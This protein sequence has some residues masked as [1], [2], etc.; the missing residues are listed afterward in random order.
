[1]RPSPFDQPSKKSGLYEAPLYGRPG[2]RDPRDSYTFEVFPARPDEDVSDWSRIPRDNDDYDPDAIGFDISAANEGTDYVLTISTS[3]RPR[4]QWYSRNQFQTRFLYDPLDPPRPQGVDAEEWQEYAANRVQDQ[5]ESTMR[6]TQDRQTLLKRIA[7]LWNGHE[8]C[9]VHLLA[10]QCPTISHLSAD[11]DENT[12]KRLYYNTDLGRETLLAFGDAD[13]FDVTPGFLKSTTVF[14]KRAWYD[15]NT[16]AQT[17]IK[18]RDEFPNLRGD[19]YGGLV[20]RITIG[21]VCLHDNIRGWNSDSYHDWK[22]YTIDAIANDQQG[23]G[24]A[25]EVLTEHNNYELYRKTYR[26]MQKLD[27][28]GVTTKAVFDSRE[29]A[30]HVFNHWHRKGLG[31]LP[32]GTF[33]SEYCVKDGQD[34]IEDAYQ[35]KQHEWAIP[36]WTT[37]WKLKEKTLGPD[38]P[39]LSRDEILSL[40]W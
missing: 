10:D 13:W 22:G 40:N 20:H 31:E 21:L 28:H 19:Q 29:T 24:H 32:N 6:L 5:T 39:E 7:R 16:K 25:R 4:L 36:D 37:T 26:K 34:A 27:Q 23:Q 30:Y 11:I 2:S 35:S 1:M 14:R 18:E 9:D 15:L 8:V 38:G 3:D 17:L 12:L 33:D